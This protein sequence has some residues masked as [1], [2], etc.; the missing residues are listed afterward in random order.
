MRD[1]TEHSVTPSDGRRRQH[2]G[3][4]EANPP[5]FAELEATNAAAEVSN[6]RVA[7]DTLGTAKTRTKGCGVEAQLRGSRLDR[8]KKRT[9]RRP[10]PLHRCLLRAVAVGVA[11]DSV[12]NSC[13]D[14]GWM[15]GKRAA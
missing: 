10:V 4:W 15:M 7:F 8:F 3:L 6:D 13:C 1:K 12:V 2:S 5:A 14:A 11:G 9:T